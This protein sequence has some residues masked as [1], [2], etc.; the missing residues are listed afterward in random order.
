MTE[1]QQ[2]AAARKML[3]EMGD[4]GEVE[5]EEEERDKYMAMMGGLG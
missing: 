5:I 2:A 1:E 3:E 4:E